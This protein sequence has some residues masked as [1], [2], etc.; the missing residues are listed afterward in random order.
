MSAYAA[1]SA[2]P[3]WAVTTWVDRTRLYVEFPSIHGPLVL[4]YPRTPEGFANA[5]GAIAMR[6]TDA[7][8]GEFH[9]PP[10]PIPDR[11][12]ATLDQRNAV[13]AFLRKKGVIR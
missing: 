8:S 12:G 4:D 10:S 11:N 3:S 5:L 9:P 2:A 7:G 6:H 13:D 1:P